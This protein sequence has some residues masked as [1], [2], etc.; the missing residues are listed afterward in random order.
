MSKSTI[1]SLEKISFL[2]TDIKILFGSE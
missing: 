2:Q 1:K